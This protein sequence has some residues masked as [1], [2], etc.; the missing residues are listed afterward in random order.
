MIHVKLYV[1]RN[2]G[3]VTGPTDFVG[4]F[5]FEHVPAAGDVISYDFHSY[6]VLY[7]TW[8]P[9]GPRDS[10]PSSVTLHLERRS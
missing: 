1:N 5:Q 2:T 10:N 6:L 3:N 8:Q 9:P 4:E 7:R